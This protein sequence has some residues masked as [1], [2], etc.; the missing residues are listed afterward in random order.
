MNN[1]RRN[2][3]T[4]SHYLFEKTFESNIK[5]AVYAK[6]SPLTGHTLI[7][8]TLVKVKDII[9]H[10]YRPTFWIPRGLNWIFLG[11]KYSW[12]MHLALSKEKVFF[13]K[14]VT[15]NHC[16]LLIIR[17]IQNGHTFSVSFSNKAC[18]RDWNIVKWRR[19]C[20]VSFLYFSK[21]RCDQMKNWRIV[22]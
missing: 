3:S 18:V 6:A 4:V 11:K 15:L 10:I 19:G 20:K 12:I 17:K 2:S 5:K 1:F 9:D 7:F 22:S 8:G 21:D 13:P 14:W 16:L